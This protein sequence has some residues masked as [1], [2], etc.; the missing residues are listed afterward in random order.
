MKFSQLNKLDQARYALATAFLLGGISFGLWFVHIP[1]VTARLNLSATTLGWVFLTSAVGA[2]IAQL[3]MGI[4]IAR[5]GS[6]LALRLSLPILLVTGVLPII[7]WNVEFL[8]FAALIFGAAAGL[9]NIAVNI[10]AS[11]LQAALKRP[12]M[13][14]FHGFFS[15]GGIVAAA[16]GSVII[17]IG[18]A[19][20]AGASLTSIIILGI[21][22]YISRYYLS[23]VPE[24]ETAAPRVKSSFPNKALMALAIMAF[25]CQMIEGAIG[26][27]SGLFLITI[28]QASPSV[29]TVGYAALSFAMAFVRFSGAAIINKTS[30]KIV[31][32]IGGSFAVFGV[33]IVIASPWAML[34]AFGF[35]IIGVGTANILPILLGTAGRM[36]GIKAGSAVA[37]T[38]TTGQMGLILGPTIIGFIAESY[39]LSYGIGFLAIMAALI[40]CCGVVRN[41][42]SSSF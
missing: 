36:G 27:W 3:A 22:F 32:M 18:W 28:K 10:Q 25:A 9:Y 1:I 34:S 40:A 26:D 42:Q 29:A 4:T 35:F 41:W 12:S 13:S 19:D 16:L 31:V 8:F 20:G 14:F 17:A 37:I 2:A 39:S 6:R 33:F 30:E 11:H 38:A 24:T 7:A 15:L 21:S 23:H 5:L